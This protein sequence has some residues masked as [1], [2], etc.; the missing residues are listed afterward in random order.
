VLEVNIDGEDVIFELEAYWR[1]STK[2]LEVELPLT[3]S[4]QDEA[5]ERI[6]LALDELKEHF[7]W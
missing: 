5:D 2:R 6:Q 7:P 1:D 3:L 4:L